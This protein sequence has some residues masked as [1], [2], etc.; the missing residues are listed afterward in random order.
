MDSVRVWLCDPCDGVVPVAVDDLARRL[1]VLP[2]R[3]LH[4]AAGTMALS[5]CFNVVCCPPRV[6]RLRADVFLHRCVDCYDL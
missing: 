5:V 6:V 1:G 4:Q 3:E 2:V